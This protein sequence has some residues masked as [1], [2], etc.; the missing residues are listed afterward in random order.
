M[1]R[2]KF[3]INPNGVFAFSTP[4]SELALELS[5]EDLFDNR[6]TLSHAKI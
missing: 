5:D 1:G 4:S 3:F 2:G 6:T